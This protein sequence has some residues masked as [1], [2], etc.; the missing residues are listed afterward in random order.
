MSR[1]KKLKILRLGDNELSSLGNWISGLCELEELDLHENMLSELPGGVNELEKLSELN[2][3][4]TGL[5]MS[6]VPES[7]RDVAVF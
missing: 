5:S 7:L 2:L 6:D 1:L 3:W 4:G